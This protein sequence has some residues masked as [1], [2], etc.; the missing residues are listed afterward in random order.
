MDNWQC[1]QRP[2]DKRIAQLHDTRTRTMRYEKGAVSVKVPMVQC[3][4][5]RCN[6]A[7]RHSNGLLA[8]LSRRLAW[9]CSHAWLLPTA[10][11]QPADDINVPAVHLLPVVFR[12]HHV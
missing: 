2:K 10:P 7:M 11:Q 4:I 6:E 12:E 5:F 9:V 3:S 8:G 1:E